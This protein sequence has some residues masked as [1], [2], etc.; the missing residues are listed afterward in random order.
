MTAIERQ[1]DRLTREW[2]TALNLYRAS[3]TVTN[4]RLEQEAYDRLVN[5]VEANGLNYSVYDPR[6]QS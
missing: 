4:D 2:Q 5:Y 3:A 6:E 1:V